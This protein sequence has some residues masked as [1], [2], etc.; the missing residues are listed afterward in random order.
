MWIIMCCI[1]NQSQWAL[2]SAELP[3]PLL[4]TSICNEF[5]FCRP[6]SLSIAVCKYH[7]F[8]KHKDKGTRMQTVI[9]T[10]PRGPWN[11]KFNVRKYQI[12][13]ST[14]RCSPGRRET[15]EEERGQRNLFEHNAG[16]G[17][18]RKSKLKRL[19][20]SLYFWCIMTVRSTLTLF[21]SLF[22]R[23]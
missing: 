3:L 13:L 18:R 2:R 15:W 21:I 9:C 10:S 4:E 7:M 5:F 6:P 17:S 16:V 14:C 8:L 1:F 23:P 20:S 19:L 22:L 11:D 12:E